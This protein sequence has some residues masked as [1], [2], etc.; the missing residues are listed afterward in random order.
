MEMVRDIRCK[1]CGETGQVTWGQTQW[2]PDVQPVRVPLSVNGRFSIC[3][4]GKSK[5]VA[6]D[7][8]QQIQSSG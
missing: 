2:H 1:G 8:C 6:C 5:A 7:R 3:D 4:H